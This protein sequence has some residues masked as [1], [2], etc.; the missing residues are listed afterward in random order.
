MPKNLVQEYTPIIKDINKNST[1]LFRN[2]REHSFVI[3]LYQRDYNW[4]DEQIERLFT[5]FINSF[6]NNKHYL[7]SIIYIENDKR[8]EIIDG[9]QRITSCYLMLLALLCLGLKFANEFYQE[10]GNQDLFYTCKSKFKLFKT[11]LKDKIKY[12]YR[13]QQQSYEN[14][15]NVGIVEVFEDLHLKQKQIDSIQ[16]I[17][18]KLDNFIEKLK[19]ENKGNFTS[20]FLKL[21]TL[22]EERF[23]D[24]KNEFNS[25]LEKCFSDEIYSCIFVEISDI[26]HSMSVFKAINTTGVKLTSADLIRAYLINIDYKRNSKDYIEITQS[27]EKRLKEHFKNKSNEKYCEFWLFFIK[28]ILIRNNAIRER[29]EYQINN[30]K[31]TISSANPQKIQVYEDFKKVDYYLG[32]T[33]SYFL[34]NDCKD[35]IERYFDYYLLLRKGYSSHNNGG[36][37]EFYK[38]LKLKDKEAKLFNLITSMTN[39]GASPLDTFIP[40][41]F[42]LFE[43]IDDRRIIQDVEKISTKVFLKTMHLLW[44]FVVRVKV[45]ERYY[46]ASK[47]TNVKINFAKASE[48]NMYSTL[49]N[50]INSNDKDNDKRMS[51]ETKSSFINALLEDEKLNDKYLLTIIN[52]HNN[53]EV[54]S[55]NTIEHVMPQNALSKKSSWE[56]EDDQTILRDWNIIKSVIGMPKN[57]EV[58]PTLRKELFEKF[59]NSIGNKILLNSSINYS[60]KD[61]ILSYKLVEYD[62]NCN[63][64]YI[65]EKIKEFSPEGKWGYGSIIN[66]CRFYGEQIF[67]A[68][69]PEE[70][71]NP[72]N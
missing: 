7:G 42:V 27:I 26:K 30:D 36:E 33:E 29:N 46:G 70:P 62:K 25:L 54:N 31:L 34:N 24:K 19:L 41:L 1:D 8:Y 48:E 39:L 18:D 68:C 72:K 12:E 44:S 64:K 67:D 52:Y 59:K 56:Q 37:D 45:N 5:D 50:A 6:E 2:I 10:N 16:S 23:R 14:L 22:F 15:M 43:R 57:E 60:V 71:K 11:A 47:I 4:G 65:I 35:L 17:N 38:K 13:K 66:M 61:N 32:E 9:Q 51:E 63:N 53:L 28:A 40:D 69:S 55:E 20:N 49:Y 58:S 3:P 21:Y